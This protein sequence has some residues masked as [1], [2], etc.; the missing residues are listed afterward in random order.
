MILENKWRDSKLRPFL[1]SLPECEYFIKEAVS[2]RALPDIVGV[3]RGLPFYLEVKRSISELSCPRTKLQDYT[4]KK[5]EKAGAFT[6]FIYPENVQEVLNELIAEALV[7][8]AINIDAKRDLFKRV[9][10]SF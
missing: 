7:R 10:D 2:I 8:G 6:S 1:D 3:W 9:K 5:F 4:L